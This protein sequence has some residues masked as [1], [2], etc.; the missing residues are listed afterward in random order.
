MYGTPMHL[1]LNTSFKGVNVGSVFFWIEIPRPGQA[2]KELHLP[3]YIVTMGVIHYIYIYVSL[4]IIEYLLSGWPH[5]AP[6][7]LYQTWMCLQIP[8]TRVGPSGIKI[9]ASGTG[10]LTDSHHLPACPQKSAKFQ[11][12]HHWGNLFPNNSELSEISTSGA[13][14]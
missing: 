13:F 10:K 2:H 4:C 9:T 11:F 6:M 3:L 14:P 8:K 7:G 12:S 1:R 5:V